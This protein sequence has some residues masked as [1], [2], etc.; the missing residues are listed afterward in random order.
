MLVI[1][2]SC[3]ERNHQQ[4][5]FKYFGIISYKIIPNAKKSDKKTLNNFQKVEQRENEEDDEK[6]HQL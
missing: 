1:Y 4:L 5:T 2:R 3:S 6:A